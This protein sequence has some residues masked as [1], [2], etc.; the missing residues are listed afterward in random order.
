MIYSGFVIKKERLRRNWSQEGLCKGI[1]AVSYLSKIE[2]G[3]TEASE[4]ILEALF[5]KLGISWLAKGKTLAEGREFI[6]NWY[7]AVFSAD[8]K[9]QE[10]YCEKAKSEF[11]CLENSELAPDFMLLRD[12]LSDGENAL[13]ERLEPCMDTRALAIQKLLKGEYYE[14]EKLYPSAFLYQRTGIDAYVRGDEST[15]LEH[16]QKAY[17]LAAREGRARLMMLSKL[18]IS[19]C[20]SNMA[21]IEA[22]ERHGKIAKRLALELGEEEYAE[23]LDYNF[24][25]TKIETGDYEGAYAY[26]SNLKEPSAFSLHKLAIC[27]EKLGKT[28]EALAAIEKEKEGKEEVPEYKSIADEACAI[29]R[30]R[31]EN[32]NYLSDEEYGARLLALF[33]RF[34]K[35]MPVGYARFH[36]PWVLEWYTANRRYKEAFELMKEF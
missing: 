3:K 16:L 30:M 11:S 36:L 24:A 4:E 6:E 18:F 15:A 19:N 25:A 33:S 7:E 26:F 13:D 5:K 14:A 10:I 31:L 28:E 9:K 23:T 20:Y 1:C 22:M 29:V 17:D 8:I 12:F 2:Q 35:E 32:E 21:D 27:C 34:R